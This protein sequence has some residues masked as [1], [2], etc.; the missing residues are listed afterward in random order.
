MNL[1][2]AFFDAKQYDIDFF[3]KANEAFG[4]EI[5]FLA[6]KLNPATAQLTAGFD[7]V[8]A[9]VNDDLSVKTISI[10]KDKGIKL[11]AMRSAGYNNVDLRAAY[12][13][14][15]VVRVPAYSPHAV[16]EHAVALLLTLNRKTHRAYYRTRDGNFTL[17]GLMGFDLN[18][19]VAG[20]VGTGKIGRIT[21]EIL[22]GFGM[23]VL[24]SDPY[25]D[26]EWA[27][28]CGAEYVSRDELFR[29]ADV[30][31]LHCP[32]TP[33]TNHLINAETIAM[34]KD[35]VI[36]VN[37]GRGALVDTKALIE[38]LKSG[39]VGSAGLDVYEEE[40][41]YFFEDFSVRGVADD[42]LA[43]LLTFPNVLVTAHQAFFTREALDAIAATTLGN[44]AAYF[45]R[46]ELP[47]EVCYRCAQGAQGD[48]QRKRTGRCF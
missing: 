2:V 36:L 5:H 4:M 30:I 43:R 33:E 18:G 29:Q 28:K 42:V 46:G 41:D 38:G 27:A 25:E 17:S 20:I 31:S 10:L 21:A 16:A 3:K 6:E 12:E 39:K 23:R 34:L 35:G 8:V 24:V 9:F 22:R 32:L 44:I 14:I 45:E 37:T 48:C 1:S 40:D 15:H 7:A 19:H 47:N 13:A 26:R 11:I